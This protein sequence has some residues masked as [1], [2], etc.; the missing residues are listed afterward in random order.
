MGSAELPTTRP[1]SL[2]NISLCW[3]KHGK[4]SAASKNNYREIGSPWRIPLVV[5]NNSVLPPLKWTERI[6]NEL[7]TSPY[8]PNYDENPSCSWL[9]PNRS[10]QLDHRL[11]FVISSLRAP[12][13]CSSLSSFSWNVNTR[14]P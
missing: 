7:L 1:S 2:P 12:S 5:K 10:I 13:I 6:Q 8:P 3:S 4:P 9:S 14:L 11:N